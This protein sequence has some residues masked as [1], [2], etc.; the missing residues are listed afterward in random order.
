ML[1]VM[2]VGNTNLVMGLYDGKELR[3]HWRLMTGGQRTADE[4][5][6]TM[7]LML[8]EDGFDPTDITACC[9][10]S[11]VPP[12]NGVLDQVAR[13]A[14]NVDPLFVGPG[15]RTGLV[16]QVENPKEVGADRI[17]NCVGACAAYEGPLIVIDF[18]T[19]TTFDVVT[20]RG[21]YRGGAIVPGIQIAADALFERCAKL[22]RVEI[23]RPPHVIGRDTLS[24]IRSGLTYGYADLV[25][26][27]IRRMRDE[28]DDK[29]TVVATGGLATLIAEIAS[30]IHHVD[31]WL[32]L[33]GLRVVHERNRKPPS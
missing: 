28:L 20:A 15:T 23:S 10:A 27:L 29:P 19:A 13:T 11:V 17:V 21:E 3:G 16:V 30:E 26:G 9:I 8:R 2:D 31:P 12:L 22:P 4:V 32:T 1:L 18:G 5:R 33:N 25:D 7:A 6:L 14:F 24:H